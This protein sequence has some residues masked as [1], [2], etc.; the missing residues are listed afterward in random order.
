MYQ[1]ARVSLQILYNQ[2]G[3]TERHTHRYGHCLHEHV[4]AFRSFFPSFCPWGGTSQYS[5]NG[6]L[7]HTENKGEPWQCSCYPSPLQSC[8][9]NSLINGIIVS[10]SSR[11]HGLPNRSFSSLCTFILTRFA[12]LPRFA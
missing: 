3:N 7:T 8:I 1:R 12:F 6:T 2:K 5:L 10:E 11:L 4:C 9:N